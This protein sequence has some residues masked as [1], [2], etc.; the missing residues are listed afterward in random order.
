MIVGVQV[1]E[2]FPV[3]LQTHQGRGGGSPT[4]HQNRLAAAFE[5]VE[6]LAEGL[7]KLQSVHGF[8]VFWQLPTCT[9]RCQGAHAPLAAA[10]RH[11]GV[12]VTAARVK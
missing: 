4:A 5:L 8:H 9:V 2:A 12:K 7:T 11:I 6:H 1:D 10:G 3:V